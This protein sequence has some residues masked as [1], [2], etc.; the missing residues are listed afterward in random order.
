MV[1]LKHSP[2]WMIARVKEYLDGKGSYKNIARQHNISY[3][4]LRLWTMKFQ[5]YGAA[6]FSVES[7][8]NNI[9]VRLFARKEIGINIPVRKPLP[10]ISLSENLM[11]ADQMKNGLRMLLRLKFLAVVRSST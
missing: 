11:P 10:K 2:E 3:S 8:N 6:A 7:K 1:K 9:S 4:N 5:L